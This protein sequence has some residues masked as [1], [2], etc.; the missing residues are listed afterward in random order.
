MNE[1]F[2]KARL[3]VRSSR[4]VK[5]EK[6]LMGVL[7]QGTSERDFLFDEAALSWVGNRRSRRVFKKGPV[8]MSLRTDGTYRVTLDIDLRDEGKVEDGFGVYEY[9]DEALSRIEEMQLFFRMGKRVAKKKG[10]RG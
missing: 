10:G 9:L 6:P 3:L 1:K 2:E 7:T 5:K 8:A 4:G